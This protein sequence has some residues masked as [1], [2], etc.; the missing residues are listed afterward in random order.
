MKQALI[1][2]FSNLTHDARVQRQ[3]RWLHKHFR[4]TA[5]AYDGHVADDVELIPVPRPKLKHLTRSWLSVLLVL[6]LFHRAYW[7]LYRYQHL[8]P[9]LRVRDFDLIVANDVESLP[10]AFSVKK[11]ARVWIDAHEFAPRH[12]EEK[13]Y[14]RIFFQRFNRF[15]CRTYLPQGDW[16]TTVSEGLRAA[17]EQEFSVKPVVLTNATRYHELT[18]RP[19][20]AQRIRI[21]HHG[22]A[23]PSRH[24][25]LLIEMMAHLDARFT[26]DFMLITPALAN[27]KTSS[28]INKLKSLAQDPRI[29]FQPPVPS[30]QIVEF[31]HQYDLGIFVLPPVNFNYANTL[32]N[33]LFDFI[34]ARLGIAIGPTPEMV[35]VVKQFNMGVVADTF[36]PADMAARLNALTDHDINHFKLQAHQAARLLSA[37]Q[38][39]LLV[40]K[41]LH[42]LGLID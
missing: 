10:L 41:A 39:E 30:D 38:N 8:I 24:L 2:S 27:T 7:T 36:D 15:L 26:L 4:V 25:E 42:R 5:I 31:I 3:V 17:Y 29:T 9:E 19:V 40:K 32:P 1:I 33:K 20:D 6:R 12:F 23:N 37:E 34:Q 16:M 11:R 21:I 22:G 35:R 28:Y 14:W 13:L 18:P